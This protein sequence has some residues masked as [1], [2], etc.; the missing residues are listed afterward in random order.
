VDLAAGEEAVDYVSGT[1]GVPRLN[2][3]AQLLTT[4]ILARGEDGLYIID[5]H[6]AHERVLY[7]EFL[8]AGRAGASQCLLVPVVLE[9]DYRETAVLTEKVLWFN[10]AGFVIE[11]FGGN[12]FLLRGVPLQLPAGQEKE[13]F[14]DMLDYFKERGPGA[15]RVEFY[16][17]L[18]S[19]MACRN[20]IKAGEK[21]SLSSMEALL[22]RLTRTETPYT[23]P[24][25]RPTVIHLS[26]R[27]LETRFK[28]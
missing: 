7:E 18:A 9:L 17:R 21:L 12:T 1:K 10:D 28:R 24:H 16:D 2:V 8:S 15:S 11:H 23:C 13:F 14:L 26:Y 25:G 19:S 20:A 6:A 27:D 4:Y 3:L 5:Q 22:A